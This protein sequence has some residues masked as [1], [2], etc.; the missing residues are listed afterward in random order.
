MSNLFNMKRVLFWSGVAL[1][2]LPHAVMAQVYCSSSSGSDA[3]D[4]RTEQTAVRTIERASSL[5]RDIRLKGDDTFFER[6]SLVG[7][8]DDPYRISAYGEGMPR[9]AGF[10][11]VPRG[12]GLWKR[13]RFDEQLRWVPDRKG[14]I[15]RIDLWDKHVLGMPGTDSRTCDI[16][17]IY[18]PSTDE[19]H[20]IRC[21]FRSPTDTIPAQLRGRQFARCLTDDYDFYQPWTSVKQGSD[22]VL[23]MPDDRYLYVKYAS[24]NLNRQELWLSCGLT[25]VS[26]HYVTIEGL[27]ILGWGVHGVGTG[28]HTN[29]LN[30]KIDIIGGALF[31][32]YSTGTRYGNGIEFYIAR[33]A[34]DCLCE[35][36]EISRTFDCGITIQGA[37]C[38]GAT[39]RNIV[40]RRNTLRDCRQSLEFWLNNAEPDA[41][42]CP[43]H[44]DHCLAEDNLCYP[45]R[46]LYGREQDGNNSQLL[47]Y[48]GAQPIAGLT[49]CG[50][51]FIGGDTYH[52]NNGQPCASLVDNTFICTPGQYLDRK[53]LRLSDN[54]EQEV[55]QLRLLTGERSLHV[56]VKE[57]LDDP[58]SREGILWESRPLPA[59]YDSLMTVRTHQVETLL[60]QQGDAF[61]FW[62]DTHTNANALSTPYLMREL[63]RR[64]PN[65]TGKVVWGGDAIPAF[66]A[67]VKRYWSLQARMNGVVETF[68]RNYNVRGNHD[69]TVRY[70]ADKP[71]GRTCSQAQTAR[72]LY[73]SMT[74]DVVRNPD[75]TTGCYYYFDEPTAHIRYIVLE[76]NDTSGAPDRAW[77]VNATVGERQIHWVFDHVV[78]STPQGWGLVFISHVPLLND[79]APRTQDYAQLRERI[80]Q[81][82]SRYPH[83]R[84]LMVLSGHEH[85][86]YASYEE[87]ILHVVTSC[88]A[89]YNDF[90]CSPLHA[91]E[92]L[93]ER[94]T[95]REQCFDYV[96]VDRDSKNI[97]MLRFGN[98]ASRS[99]ALEPL[100][101]RLGECLSLPA[102]GDTR[103]YIHD[104]RGN[105]C[106]SLPN[107][108]C[109]WRWNQTVADVTSDA[110][111][112]AL[113][114][115]ESVLIAVNPDG[116]EHY[117]AVVVESVDA[118]LTKRSKL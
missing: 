85:Y 25:G 65:A 116:T 28:T 16:G 30:C 104:A 9:I 89:S 24:G 41:P 83:L 35:G 14:D 72:W 99:F 3:N 36:N 44:F 81:I 56:I 54:P 92:A 95:Y 38:P 46:S 87:G 22:E 74:A 10:K 7:T 58:L 94:N 6:I 82:G 45:T 61:L 86:D 107:Y 50:N 43:L 27:H 111:L 42:D 63:L 113:T 70:A 29:V 78:P 34:S 76:T 47:F 59:G 91:E 52:F 118:V 68:A 12:K 32:G 73:D 93:A 31:Q 101:L 114:P 15:F 109:R 62:T 105:V 115:G 51:T 49:I 19:I 37:G 102:D 18:A 96:S 97:H 2:L 5:G 106:E 55:E 17:C 71:E 33:T 11:V 40:F 4:G 66:A 53:Q 39:A 90:R 98:C 112:R 103:W 80:E 1:S 8:E 110:Q 67:D 48:Q 20:G 75:D 79:M 100:R 64:V 84:V 13:G 117:Q 23:S 26:A 60:P 77:G 108:Q 57:S 88:N 21:G 69:F